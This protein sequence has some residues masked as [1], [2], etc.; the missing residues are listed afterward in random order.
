MSFRTIGLVLITRSRSGPAG[1]QAG[2]PSMSTRIAGTLEKITFGGS[3][4]RGCDSPFFC[5]ARMAW[6]ASSRSRAIVTDFLFRIA[7][8]NIWRYVSSAA[9]AEGKVTFTTWMSVSSTSRVV[10]STFVLASENMTPNVGS[11]APLEVMETAACHSIVRPSQASSCGVYSAMA[12]SPAVNLRGQRSSGAALWA[13]GAG[14]AAGFA[15]C[16][17]SSGGVPNVSVNAAARTAAV[18]RWSRGLMGRASFGRRSIQERDVFRPGGCYPARMKKLQTAIL[19]LALAILCFLPGAAARAQNIPG[20]IELTAVGG[21]YFGHNIYQNARTSIETGTTYEY[22]ARLGVDLTEGIG[23]EGSWTYAK[24][25]LNAT[26]ILPE[27]LEGTIGDV[28]TNIYELDGLFSVGNDTASFYVVLGIGAT[29]FEPEIGGVTTA[30][31]TYLSGSAGIG[32]KWWLGRNFGLRIEGRWRW[33]ATGHTTEA[34]AW[35]DPFGICYGY[36]T[37]VYGHPDITG[38]LTLRF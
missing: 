23:I 4:F 9:G 2:S 27:G 28:K 11:F 30:T 16:A 18:N 12:L 35:C 21:G 14:A 5:S 1:R 7:L 33:V 10:L 32:G 3:F 22:G 38:G 8:R 6:F 20:S 29:S 37:S 34:G 24:P 36:T 25:N 31:N 19:V 15:V 26:R 13:A 17:K